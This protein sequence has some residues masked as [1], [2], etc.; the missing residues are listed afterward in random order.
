VAKLAAS[1]AKSAPRP[2]LL[3]LPHALQGEVMGQNNTLAKGY[4]DQGLAIT[5]WDEADLALGAG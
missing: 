4:A 3:L 5:F 2:N 1:L